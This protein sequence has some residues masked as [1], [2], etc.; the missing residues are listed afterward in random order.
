[1]LAVPF[2]PIQ[3]RSLGLALGPSIVAVGHLPQA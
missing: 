1:M 2:D 3:T